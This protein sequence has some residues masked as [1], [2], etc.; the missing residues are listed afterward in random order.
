MTRIGTIVLA[1]RFL[2]PAELRAWCGGV[3]AL[4]STMAELLAEVNSA[5][6]LFATW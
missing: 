6:Q 5:L 4:A 2:T 1:D 3:F